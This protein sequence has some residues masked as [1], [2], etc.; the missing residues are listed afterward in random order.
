M[1]IKFT[2]TVEFLQTPTVNHT[3][4][5]Q[6]LHDRGRGLKQMYFPWYEP[7]ESCNR[8][9]STYVDP[10]DEPRQVADDRRQ[11]YFPWFSEA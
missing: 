11:L 3:P 5:G 1:T 9:S 10:L 2:F 6:E 7:E 4:V 8:S